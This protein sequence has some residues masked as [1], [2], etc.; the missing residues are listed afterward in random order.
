MAKYTIKLVWKIKAPL[1]DVWDAIL[2]THNWPKWWKNIRQ[3]KETIR[4]FDTGTGSLRYYKLRGIL[5]YRITFCIMTTNVVQYEI[6]EGDIYGDIK[7]N[8][9]W[10]FSKENEFIIVHIIWAVHDTKPLT[11]IASFFFFYLFKWNFKSIFKRGAKSL[12][13]YLKAPAEIPIL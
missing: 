8:I 1:E 4:G 12:T 11:Y 3:V 6:I 7:G 13:R 2:N 9:E 10:H 5:P